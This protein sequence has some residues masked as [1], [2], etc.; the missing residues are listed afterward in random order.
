MLD[1][2]RSHSVRLHS[3]Q[4]NNKTGKRGEVR[5]LFFLLSFN[6]CHINNKGTRAAKSSDKGRRVPCNAAMKTQREETARR[7][8]GTVIV[9]A[10]TAPRE[11]KTE[12]S[13]SC[14]GDP[15]GTPIPRA[16]VTFF[17]TKAATDGNAEAAKA[18]SFSSSSVEL[19]ANESTPYP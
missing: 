19:D 2:F 17:P 3:Q 11:R 14:E 8:C 7:Q 4:Q 15:C 16:R 6:I 12:A 10:L 18:W 9:A 13:P 1:E 5:A